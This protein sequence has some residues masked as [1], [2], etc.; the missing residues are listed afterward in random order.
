MHEAASSGSSFWESEWIDPLSLN[1]ISSAAKQGLSLS[2]SAAMIL[3]MHGAV[4][5]L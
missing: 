4:P 2:V 3:R 5:G 1:A